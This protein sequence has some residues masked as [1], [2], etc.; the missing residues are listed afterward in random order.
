MLPFKLDMDRIALDPWGSPEDI[1]A[2]TVDGPILVAGKL[3]FGSF[4]TPVSGGL[5]S[6]TKGKYRVTYPFHEHATLLDGE[7][8][9]TDE[10]SGETVV[11]G[12]GDSWIIAKGT[13]VL[14]NIRSPMIRKSYLATTVDL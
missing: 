10:Q 6:A 12:P 8:A 3:L 5:Y 2:T 9:I 11:Y 1:G 4:D 14:W 13:A 7:L